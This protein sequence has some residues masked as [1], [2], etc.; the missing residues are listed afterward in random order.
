VNEFVLARMAESGKPHYYAGFL[1][2]TTTRAGRALFTATPTLA[3][4]FTEIGFAEHE[5]RKHM[6]EN[7]GVIP[8]PNLKEKP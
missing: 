8:A 2:A 5:R 4:R 6:L 3:K 7:T 1:P